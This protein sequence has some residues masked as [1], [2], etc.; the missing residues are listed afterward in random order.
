MEAGTES[1]PSL[2]WWGGSCSCT[3]G[4]ILFVSHMC[5]RY[6]T[7]VA[8]G[9]MEY[10]VHTC[11]RSPRQPKDRSSPCFG[12]PAHT[13][14]RSQGT[15]QI[16]LALSLS[17]YLG[18]SAHLAGDEGARGGLGPGPGCRVGA[19]PPELAQTVEGGEPWLCLSSA[20]PLLP[21]FCSPFSDLLPP[22]SHL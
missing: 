8:L 22:P 10:L 20:V 7:R 6:E 11:W 16:S 13:L 1:G 18:L 3:D 4:S 12:T 15:C 19:G 2:L 14:A 5:Y 17:V 21:L 9:Q